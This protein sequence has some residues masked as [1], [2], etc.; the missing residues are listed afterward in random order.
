MNTLDAWI[1]VCSL[2]LEYSA[3]VRKEVR[4]L[5]RRMQSMSPV[6]S[7]WANRTKLLL[8]IEVCVVIVA[9]QLLK[10][11][12]ELIRECLYNRI[13]YSD[14]LFIKQQGL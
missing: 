6:T 3:N 5:L 7:A 4:D 12:V 8:N 13:S 10:Y 2:D 11:Y 1:S 14:I 9:L